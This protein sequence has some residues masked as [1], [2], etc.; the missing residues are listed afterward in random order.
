MRYLLTLIF[1]LAACTPQDGKLMKKKSQ[2]EMKK[3]GQ[4]TL[5]NAERNRQQ[6]R[7]PMSPFSRTFTRMDSL[8]GSITPEREWWDLNYYHINLKVDA[9]KRYFDGSVLVRY[10]VLN[11]YDKIQIDLQK[12]LQIDKVIQNGEELTWTA[13][14][15]AHFIQL[16]ADQP[17]NSFQELTVHYSGNPHVARR[18][19][20]DGGI[21]FTKD[22]NGKHFIA[23]SCQGIGPSIWW[24]NKDIPYD[25]PDSVLM[26]ITTPGDLMNVGNGRMRGMTENADGTKTWKW[27][28]SNPINNYGININIGDYV[29]FGEKFAGEKGELTLD[30]YV[31]RENLE[32]AKKH[33]KVVPKMMKAFEH[34][35]GP[36]P[37]Y[38]DGYKLVEA[39]YLGMEHQS[40]VTYGNKYMMGYLGRDLSQT[41]YGKRFDF[42]IIHET[43]HEWF[44]N[45]ITYKDVADMWVHEGFTAYSEGLFVDYM[46]G[47]EAGTAYTRGTRS[48]I[49]NVMPMIGPYGVDTRGAG[50]DIYYK[51]ANILNMIRHIIDDDEKW[52]QI[53][54]GLNKT[55]YHQTV[56]TKQ[57]EDYIIRESGKDLAPL[58]DQ[59]LRDYRIPTLQYRQ[60]KDV[61]TLN[62]NNCSMRFRMPVRVKVDGI[63]RVVEVGRAPVTISGVKPNA[64]V[65]VD[66]NWYIGTL[67]LTTPVVE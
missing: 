53:L 41:G 28:V 17:K 11:P 13:E 62:F 39:P 29:Y 63:W 12:P 31:L 10:K 16:K 37:F 55:F 35:F 40:S 3:Q 26:S 2:V 27:F 30:Y 8:K 45:N 21:T 54:R 47:K 15:R 58:F 36:Y 4:K 61:I 65:D 57:I 38:E 51:G 59:Y 67:D 34:W 49:Q 43:G 14:G 9:D 33:F 50:G 64:T 42:L 52:R 46:Y 24:P 7:Q 22:S 66:P 5:T 19:P 18:A 44:A 25:E 1:L 60:I 6:R 20:W 23:S 48:F 56:T 32:K